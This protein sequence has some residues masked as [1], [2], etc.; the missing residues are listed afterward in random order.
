MTPLRRLVG[1]SLALAIVAAA[2]SSTEPSRAAFPGGSGRIV[3]Q[4]YRDG[5]SA[6]SQGIF[7][8]NPDGT[9]LKRLA[10]NAYAPKWSPDGT[11]LAYYANDGAGTALVISAAD[12][13]TPRKVVTGTAGQGYPIDPSWSPDGR[14]IVFTQAHRCGA[15]GDCTGHLAILDLGSGTQKPVPNTN[16][17]DS[18]AAWSP[19]GMRLAFER[20]PAGTQPYS[21]L[22]EYVLPTN[23]VRQLSGLPP[24]SSWPSWSPDSRRFAYTSHAT[25]YVANADGSGSRRL[26]RTTGEDY[27]LAGPSS[28]SP[29]G[30]KIAFTAARF[31][32]TQSNIYTATVDGRGVVPITHTS[33]DNDLPDWQPLPGRPS[34]PVAAPRRDTQP[35]QVKAFPGS[36]RF[37]SDVKLRFSVTDDSR[38][39]RVEL[40]VYRGKKLLRH[41]VYPYVFKADGSITSQL[42]RPDRR[43]TLTF[44][45][46]AKDLAGNTSTRSCANVVYG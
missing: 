38:K 12:G 44:C 30:K 45:V 35:P 32:E 36:G 21:H 7:I 9:G 28:W 20:N 3:F 4:R 14:K 43:G 27:A 5:A 18:G 6:A 10:G 16:G 34:I 15:A 2:V 19:D 26:L 24:D 17:A 39:A 23:T 29:D 25:I 13:A 22:D 37:G 8:V 33:F 40:S 46:Q 31:D 42:Y 41:T 1:S 11:Q